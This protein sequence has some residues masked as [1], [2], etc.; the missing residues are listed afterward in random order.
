M[1]TL[2]AVTYLESTAAHWYQDIFS[3]DQA[4]PTFVQFLEKFK[5]QFIVESENE[6]S[7]KIEKIFQ[8]SR[9]LNEYIAEFRLLKTEVRTII[10]IT[11]LYRYFIRGLRSALRDSIDKAIFNSLSFDNLIISIKRKDEYLRMRDSNYSRI[12]TLVS[13]LFF[14]SNSN[15]LTSSSQFRVTTKLSDSERQYLKDNK[16]CFRCREINANYVAANCPKF[17]NNKPAS[18]IVKREESIS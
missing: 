16:G 3:L 14:K 12:T 7:W 15:T 1:K 4:P 9:I 13:K 8:E 17:I 5:Q 18:I 10:T 11:I 2:I 6:A